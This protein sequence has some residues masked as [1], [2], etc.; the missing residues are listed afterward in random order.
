MSRLPRLSGEEVVKVL[1]SKF[2][3]KVSR[4]R[5]SHVVLVKYENGRKIGTVVPLHKELK[6]GTLLGVLHLAGISKDEFV[7]ALKD[8]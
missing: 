2:G 6:P 4:Q 8:L 1:T 3:F 7:G 5:G